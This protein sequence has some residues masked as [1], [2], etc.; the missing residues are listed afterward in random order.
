MSTFKRNKKLSNRVIS[1]GLIL[2]T[3]CLSV[4]DAQETYPYLQ[5]PTDTS[6]RITWKTESNPE[7]LVY[8]GE[9]SL[10]LSNVAIGTC[11]VLSDVGY[12]EDYF[13]HDVRLT[14]LTAGQFYFYKVVTGTRQSSIYR[15]R[16]QPEP[17]GNQGIYRFLVFGDHQVK[18]DDRY[19]RLLIAARDKV[20]EKYGG[21][22]EEHI[23]LVINDGDQV[24][25][26]TLNH[27]EFVHFGPSSVL[28]GNLPIMTTVG[29]HETY[30]SL[31]LSAYYP[32]FFYDDLGYKGIPSP[33]EEDYYSYQVKDVVFIHL[34]SEH[35]TEDQVVWVQQIVD[36]VSID[37]E[38]NWLIS[39]AHRP[40]QAEQFV[41]DISTY[42]RDRIVPI[43][44]ET[45]KSTLLIT[46]HHHLYA[47][48][49][50]RDFPMYHIISGGGSWDQY[51]GQS[52]EKD[53]DDVQKTIDFWTYQIVTLNGD[54]REMV[55]ESY[56]IGSPKLGFALDNIM[57]DSFYRKFPAV[58]PD[59]PSINESPADSITLP[60]T[61]S[62]SPYQTSSEEPHNSV[63]FQIASDSG[64][65][66][67]K[68]DLI[69]DY[70]NL[71][72]TTGNPDYL[73]VDIHDT[74]DIFKYTIRK[75][76]LAN[77]SYQVH[78]RH[79]DRNITWSEWSDPVEFKVKGSAGGF[80]AIST[81]ENLFRP[82]APIE[83]VY[84]FGPGNERDWIGV[85]RMG[86]TPGTTP[87]TDWEYVAG[88]NG[89]VWVSATENGKYFIAFFE[90]D[91]YTEI[92]DRL[93]IYISSE[94]EITLS[95]AGYDIYEEITVSYSNAP[96]IE[97]DWIGI[98]KVGDS[99]G[100]VGSTLW[101]YTTGTAGQI[102]FPEG[103]EAGYYFVNY[104][105]DN[106]YIEA[107]EREIFSV[108]S[109][110]AEVNAEKGTYRQGDTITIAF[111][112]A[113]GIDKDWIG[114]FRQSAPPGT[115]PLV[116]RKYLNG[117]QSGEM[118][119]AEELDTGSYYAALF[120]NDSY[121]R[122]SNKSNFSV[123]SGPLQVKESAP[124]D[125]HLFPNPSSGI[126]KVKFPEMPAGDVSLKVIRST[127]EVVL[128]QLVHYS[129]YPNTLDLDLSEHLPGLFF[130]H[131]E[132]MEQTQ[133][134]KFI[135]GN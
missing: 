56:A 11:Q 41:G 17:G 63:Q 23:N 71:Y 62:S 124:G 80:T 53:F 105:L 45:E 28:S 90:N 93:F 44:A 127:G 2:T 14:G 72:G 29:N 79:R 107:G 125:F 33:G 10:D 58:Q 103:L 25:Q 50:L 61:F 119:F 98:Y 86:E 24:D 12:D 31:G 83:V 74:V 35:P 130:L 60:F 135:L 77:G 126:I 104:F 134:R 37:P 114:I 106:V 117:S 68:M 91:G 8:F 76:G 75:N 112:N 121:N 43:L 38:V 47:R 92:A 70:E 99:P 55:V 88:A 89:S 133:V 52:T 67:I 131:V 100:M 113:P 48:G 84:E 49:Q 132:C 32:H 122:V 59:Q 18:S 4:L 66:D 13:Y 94:P 87:S 102:G 129:S 96:S 81:N 95:K 39:V 57:I 110:I 78:V 51:W 118:T 111:E 9:D 1:L 19:E 64:F 21:P 15:F 22:V 109:N 27:Y 36:S 3:A 128:H 40:I 85:Y 42:I 120:I 54:S 73:P 69:R 116:A 115:A 26:G 123:E 97:S 7:S 34:S 5:A 82:D 46:G 6:I 30:G 101:N 20:F 108:G 65:T 16:T